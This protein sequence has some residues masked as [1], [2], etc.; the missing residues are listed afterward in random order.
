MAKST[1]GVKTDTIARLQA[2]VGDDCATDKKILADYAA[3]GRVPV[4]VVRPADTAEV[5][6]IIKLANETG[7]NVVAASSTGPRFRGDTV[8]AEEGVIVDLSAMRKIVRVDRRN[9]VAIIEPGVTFGELQAAAARQGLKVLMPL[10]PRAGKSVL[11]SYLER[12]PILAGKFHWDMTDPLLCT[13]L[14]FG[15]GDM[16]RTGS[17]S[18]PGSLEEQWSRGMAQKNPT[19]PA[20]ADFVRIVQGAQGTMGIVT[21]ASVKLELEPKLRRLYFTQ[22]DNLKKLV[23]FSYRV[24]RAKLAD[25]LLILNGPA[26]GAILGD[27]RESVRTLAGKQAPYTCV[28]CLAGYDHLPEMRVDYEEKDVADIAQACGLTIGRQIPG[29]SARHMMGLLDAP[30]A[31]PYWK[32]RP[33][34]AFREIFFLTT[35]DRTPSFI[36]LMDDLVKR[37]G[38]A[39]ENL[40]IYIQPIQQGRSCHLEFNLFYDPSDA[41]EAEKVEQLFLE[42][43]AELAEAGA[44]FSRPYGAWSKIA[45]ARCPETVEALRKLK[46]ILDPKGVLNRGKLCFGEG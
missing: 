2:I 13:E 11:A 1:T 41:A 23:D 6:E 4:C 12:E 16:F 21:W 44:F 8:P 27:E 45:Y 25:E 31:E 39:P 3:P 18:G 24:N 15:T 29:A 36:G 9:K 7:I 43:S 35:M 40:G 37:H 5:R 26:L 38:F 28:Y 34:G 10:L 33:A 46:E 14:V 19:G 32:Q 42:A 20:S 22:S 17:A 30:S